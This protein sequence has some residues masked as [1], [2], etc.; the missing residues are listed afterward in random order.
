MVGENRQM[1]ISCSQIYEDWHHEN[2]LNYLYK[3][4]D[5]LT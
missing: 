4:I 1:I 3:K 5:T 2:Y